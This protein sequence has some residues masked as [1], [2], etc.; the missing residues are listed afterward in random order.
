M[1]PKNTWT[2]FHADVFGSF[3]W[4]TNI[5]GQKK[6]LILQ[7]NEEQKLKDN[8]GNLPFN[9]S[10]EILDDSSVKY[11][12]VYQNPGEALF[13]PSR[14]FH[15]VWNL[16]DTISINH[17]WLNACNILTIYRNMKRNL[18]EVEKEIQDCQEMENFSAHCQIMLKSVFGMSFHDFIELLRHIA[19]KRLKRMSKEKLEN[20]D[21]ENFIFGPNHVMFD[22]SHIL[23]TLEK[24][25]E[26]NR[27]LLSTLELS[28]LLENCIKNIKD[29]IT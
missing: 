17:N 19:D 11:F 4:S 16:Q 3:S 2:G 27:V 14:Y 20:A 13:V 5:C 26:E 12:T 9:I 23:N 10:E 18:D 29:T 22:L 21:F 7:P 15:Q 8:L 24:M 28:P 6:W 1:G 25:H